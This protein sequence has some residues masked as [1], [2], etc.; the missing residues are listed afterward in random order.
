MNAQHS[1]AQPGPLAGVRVLE[2]GQLIAGPFA[3]QLLGDLG[4]DVV[5]VEDPSRGDPMRNWG[6]ELP[7]GQS[8]W[9]SII[10][11]NKRSVT[12][13]L[14]TEQGQE[15]VRQLAAESDVL[16]E[17]FRP[18]TM[19]RWGL[20]YEQLSQ[21]NPGLIMVRV[22]GFGQ[23]GPYAS[24]PGYGAIGEAMGGLRYV[25]GDPS[26]P[27]SRTGI[28]IGD[29]LAAMFATIGALSALRERDQSG[30]GQ[31]VDSAIYE[32]VL[33]VMESLVPE[34]TTGGFQRER[35][36]TILPGIAPSNVYPTTDGWILIAANQDTVFSRLAAAMRQPELATD[37]RY[38]THIAR[39]ERQAEL[40]EIVADF[41][42]DK[43]LAEVEALLNEHGVPNGRIFRPRD[44]VED[45]HFA[46]RDSI[47][48]VQHPVLG[49]VAM[50]NV[51]PRL[52]RSA[53]TIRWPGPQLG[54]HTE[55]VLRQAGLSTEQIVALQE[56]GIV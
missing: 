2:L 41:T 27:P 13:D 52:S 8:L 38:A 37:E 50:Q 11:R 39:G 15:L 16:I 30:L 18:G 22:S 56:A 26:T 10:G 7:Q 24:R 40:D 36:G 23:S 21:I 17:N 1:A 47:T 48:S 46:A 49:D 33:G 31:V 6:R 42:R 9:W 28:S 29:T 53:G 25:T 4:A 32:A 45:P 55:E 35:T 20:G 43:S 19:E 54:E 5:K 34:W 51:F 12:I 44:M 3:G 14:R